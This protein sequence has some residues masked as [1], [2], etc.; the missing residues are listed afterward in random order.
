MF[1][2]VLTIGQKVVTN[3]QPAPQDDETSIGSHENRQWD[4]GLSRSCP[5]THKHSDICNT[6]VDVSIRGKALLPGLCEKRAPLVVIRDDDPR[7]ILYPLKGA[8]RR[9][10]TNKMK[11]ISTAVALLLGL[12]P[13][14]ACGNEDPAAVAAA[15]EAD[16]S[17]K[18]IGVRIV[19]GEDAFAGEF[20]WFTSSIS[21]SLCGA[22]LI[23][24]YVLLTAAHCYRAFRPGA[25]VYVKAYRFQSSSGGAVR[26]TIK[27]QVRHPSYDANS[28]ANDVMLVQLDK[29][30]TTISPVKLNKDPNVPA[31][32][33]SVMVM[34]FGTTREG[35][36]ISRDLLKVELK[37]SSNAACG[38]AY[39][40][41]YNQ[42]A[43]VCAYDDNQ[44]SCQG[45]EWVW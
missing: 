30:V 42:N 20:P 9:A 38:N 19:G 26:R 41:S 33:E 14:L 40:S 39:G 36:S 1:G 34:G 7:T 32:D 13:L 27:S 6:I 31:D 29:A 3:S 18:E 25:D 17:D 11:P 43:M 24:P 16:D 10:S 15:A 12:M 21:G 28:Y 2:P 44:D 5:N 35:G 45:G 22:S 23:S 8:A 37:K 4:S